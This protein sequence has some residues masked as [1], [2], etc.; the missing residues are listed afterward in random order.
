MYISKRAGMDHTVVPAN[1]PCLPFLRKRSP[2]ITTPN[3]GRRHPSVAYYSSIDPEGM[4]SWVGLVYRQTRPL[5]ESKGMH[6]SFH[7]WINVRVAGKTAIP[8]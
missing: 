1:T 4:K 6:G 7:S 2:G 8:R 5:L 3:W